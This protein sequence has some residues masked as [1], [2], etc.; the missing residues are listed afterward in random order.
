MRSIELRV[1]IR[2]LKIRVYN[3]QGSALFPR[4]VIS[5]GVLTWHP[6]S[7]QWFIAETPEEEHASE[8]GGCSDGPFVVDLVRRIFW[9][10]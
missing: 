1:H 8:V 6:V 3:D 4:G 7:G 10:C 9:T 2:G 5:E